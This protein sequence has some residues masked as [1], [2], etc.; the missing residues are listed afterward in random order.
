LRGLENINKT[1]EKLESS[2]DR[3]TFVVK[4]SVNGKE[5]NILATLFDPETIADHKLKGKS[6]LISKNSMIGELPTVEL[7]PGKFVQAK[8]IKRDQ[9]NDL[10][11]LEISGNL[12]K[13]IKLAASS[14]SISFS[15]MGKFL[16]SPNPENGGQISVVGNR[17]ICLERRANT[18]FLGVTTELKDN[19]LVFTTIQRRSP[20]SMAKLK[21]GDQLLAINGIAVTEPMAFSNQVQKY[22]PEETV[23]LKLIREGNEFIQEVTLK[24]RL[25]A[26]NHIAD[27]FTDGKSE[28][29]YGFKNVFVHDSKIKPSECGGPV[30]DQNGKFYGINIAR[31]SRT[32]SI[33]VPAKLVLEFLKPV[34]I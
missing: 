10:I 20:A 3:C 4:S 23:K 7:K 18:G 24:S 26:V 12:K 32:S 11:L 6:F 28:R 19:Q 30:F 8:I 31:F 2:L 22:K 5:V 1:F 34:F 15:E 13:G 27:Q 25:N 9:D 16:I 29:R 14:D 33:A 21:V 17:Q